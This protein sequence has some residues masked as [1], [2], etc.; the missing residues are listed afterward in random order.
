MEEL[1]RKRE[2]LP[3]GESR[4]VARVCGSDARRLLALLGSWACDR[5]LAGARHSATLY[6]RRAL[7][8]AVVLEEMMVALVAEGVN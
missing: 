7:Q 4:R 8:S 3:L 2:R 1:R 6:L 5:R